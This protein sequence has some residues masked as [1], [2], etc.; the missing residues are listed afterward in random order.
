[1]MIVQ[2]D[3]NLGPAVIERDTYIRTAF[4]DHLSD[5]KV[6][7]LLTPFQAAMRFGQLKLAISKWIDKYADLVNSTTKKFMKDK[8]E[9]NLDPYSYLYL[10]MKVHKKKKPIPSRLMCSCS[11]SLLEPLG[12]ADN[13][14]LQPFAQTQ[15]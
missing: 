7:K 14:L 4:R 11:G 1:M 15:P 12:L 3:K 2:C 8:L 6:Y 10:T 5:T 13:K 9:T